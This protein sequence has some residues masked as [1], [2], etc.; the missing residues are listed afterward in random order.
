MKLMADENIQSDLIDSIRHSGFEIDS[1]KEKYRG[2]SDFQLIQI[3][4]NT[5]TIMITEDKDFGEWFFAHHLPSAGVIFLRYHYKLTDTI[6]LNLVN[7]LKIN[8][9]NLKGKFLTITVDKIRVREI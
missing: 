9:E 2:Y 5:E 8:S 6:I 3:I 1:V 4:E 7:Y